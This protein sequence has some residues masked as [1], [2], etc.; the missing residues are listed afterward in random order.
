MT[1]LALTA[2]MACYAALTSN[3]APSP[4]DQKVAGTDYNAVASVPC[5][6][7]GSGATTCEAGITRAP[8]QIT[9]EIQIPGSRQRVLFFDGAGKFISHGSA[10]ADGSAALQSS[11][12]RSDDWTI[13]KVGKEEYRIPDAFVLGD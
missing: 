8:D 10:Q 4:D 9:V 12:T 7:V 1:S 13:V 2:F 6:H 5:A 11:A 3:S